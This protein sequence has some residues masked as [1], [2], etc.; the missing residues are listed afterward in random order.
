MPAFLALVPLCAWLCAGVPEYSPRAWVRGEL[1]CAGSETM[2][3][4]LLRWAEGFARHHPAANLEIDG[5]GS[6]AALHAFARSGIDFAAMSRDPD[7]SD[8]ARIGFRPVLVHVGWD[9]LRIFRRDGGAV[10]GKQAAAF[11]GPGDGLRPFGRNLAS[12]TR[13]EVQA[14]L[15]ADAISPR[16]R[17]QPSPGR[18]E[19]AVTSDPKA[20]GYGGGGWRLSRNRALGGPLKVRPLL[21]AFRAAPAS[22]L[23]REFAS[24]VLS[25][26][27]QELVEHSGFQPLDPD[28]VAVLRR[29]LGL[30]V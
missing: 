7:D 24:F 9:T 26:Q 10:A 17:S 6:R 20:V 30:D 25:R 22:P 14:S 2:Q 4:L 12:G 8:L 27:G 5:R 15:G 13:A 21:L 1:R 11:S 19:E 29:R 16:V 3:I 18:V 28:S 23:L